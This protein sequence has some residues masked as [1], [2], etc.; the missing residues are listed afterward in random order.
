[1]RN[2]LPTLCGVA[3]NERL[4][5]SPTVEDELP[6]ENGN[7]IRLTFQQ[8]DMQAFAPC[9]RMREA[10]QEQETMLLSFLDLSLFIQKGKLREVFRKS[11]TRS[12]GSVF[13]GFGVLWSR[14][15]CSNRI[16]KE[17][18][19][20][21]VRRVYTVQEA[22]PLSDAQQVAISANTDIHLKEH[23]VTL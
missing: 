3:S 14:R 4:F 12:F 5:L 11:L 9:V 6:S 13:G 23:S 21:R 20:F 19:P 8:G 7:L 1:M 16:R 18:S 10:S 15:G 2:L 22:A 17:I